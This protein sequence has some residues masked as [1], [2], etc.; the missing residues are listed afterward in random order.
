M[1]CNKQKKSY[2]KL[3]TCI[4]VSGDK[5]HGADGN[6]I[7]LAVPGGQFCSNTTVF[8]GQTVFTRHQTG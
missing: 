3:Q 2:I 1:Y 6:Q 5:E 4:C 8:V 7:I